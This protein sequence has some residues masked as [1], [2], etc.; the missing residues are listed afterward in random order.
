M[1][2]HFIGVSFNQPTF[3]S[4]ALWDP[5]ATTLA[6]NGTVGSVPYHIFIN[7][8]NTIYITISDLDLVQVWPAGSTNASR[9]ISGNL[10]TPRGS[11]VTINGDVY[12]ENGHN[13]RID[14]W[15]LNATNGVFV[16]NVTWECTGFFIDTNNV[17]YCSINDNNVVTATPISSGLSSIVAGNVSAGSTSNMLNGPNG[18]FVDINFIL[19][20]AD[21]GNARI[22]QFQP[23]QLNGT[24]VVGN[25]APGTFTLSGP[26]AVTT[27]GDGYLFI[28]DYYGNRIVGSGPNGYRCVIGCSG[29]SGSA[30]DQLYY[31]RSFS[32]DSFG[33]IFVV[34]TGNSRIQKFMLATN[35]CGK[36]D[37]IFITEVIP[38]LNSYRFNYNDTRNIS[39]Y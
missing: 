13:R 25:G 31:P 18:I 36:F 15:P 34:D 14:K 12:V 20:V 16:I 28:V 27:D 1:T 32:F 23:G 19:Y 39:K 35:S 38:S 22:Q 9:I 30:S 29:L 4:N 33:N 10:D 8:D 2:F 7:T 24:T 11:F 26:V 21:C 17:I 6:P 37:S 3:C 5:N